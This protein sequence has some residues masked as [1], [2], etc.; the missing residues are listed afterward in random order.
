MRWT[1]D[2]GD[3]DPLSAMEELTARLATLA[4]PRVEEVVLGT[5]E[6]G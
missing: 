5:D 2:F 4:A 6:V 1:V 3:V